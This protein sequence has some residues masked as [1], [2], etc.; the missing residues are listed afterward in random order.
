MLSILTKKIGRLRDERGQSFLEFALVAPLLLLTL[1]FALQF[2]LYGYAR[3][4]ATNAAQE[5]ARSAAVHSGSAPSHGAI[6]HGA[7][8][9][10]R[11]QAVEN[12]VRVRCREVL[13]FARHDEAVR[14]SI[15]SVGVAAGSAATVTSYGA[16]I[17]SN[18]K[19]DA[20]ASRMVRVTVEINVPNVLLGFSQDKV[21]WAKGVGLAYIEPWPGRPALGGEQERADIAPAN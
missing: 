2:M 11:S 10:P 8:Y 21:F 5:A 1:G 19:A 13:P 7:L 18:F 4:V 6:G 15:D 17:E 9:R 3:I 14:V 12:V 16:S 20:Q